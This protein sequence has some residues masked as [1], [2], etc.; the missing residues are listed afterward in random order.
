MRILTVVH[1]LGP[2]GTQRAAQN[3][4]L[5]YQ[6]AG[7]EVAVLAYEAGG[8]RE[9]ELQT[10]GVPV[11]SP[12]TEGSPEAAVCAAGAW[13]AD[14][15]HV[16]RNG[17]ADARSGAVLRALR[18]A[19][20]RPRVMETNVFGRVDRSPDRHLFD[21]HL[22][23]SRWCLWRWSRWRRRMEGAPGVVVP[24]S[25]DTARFYPATPEEQRAA[26]AAWDVPQDALVF[27][28]VG[29]PS[30]WKWHP[31]LFGAFARVAAEHTQAWLFLVGLPEELRPPLER[32]PAA[33]RR[34]V[35]ELP[36]LHGDAA[37]RAGYACMDVFVH[38]AEIGE[39]FGM[40]LAEAM[41]CGRP[42]ITLSRPARD[43]SQLEVVGHGEGGLVAAHERGLA[44]AMALLASQPH[45]RERL[46]RQAAA[47]TAE[48]FGQEPVM[49]LLLAVARATHEARDAADVRRRLGGIPGL[50]TGVADDDAWN[51]LDRKLGRTPLAE[52]AQMRLAHE[53]ALHAAV[54]RLKQWRY[55]TWRHPEPAAVPGGAAAPPPGP[56]SART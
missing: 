48:R 37:L 53:P 36:F 21:V 5:G 10:A 33:A 46:G 20:G 8:P 41:R 22:H 19:G 18:R 17:G 1:D 4:T 12:A 31:A 23:L 2:G 26:R 3:Y 35:R 42:V 30:R 45:Q 51:L 43:N 32:L 38:A 40:V 28:R 55:R 9:A 50:V 54:A 39:S 13:G 6:A 14:L 47:R 7:L 25:I 16:H 52:L 11:F 15:V 34:R 56:A 49:R 44:E 27:G 24:Y 29:Q